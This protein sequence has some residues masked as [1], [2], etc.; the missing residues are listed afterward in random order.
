M[1]I[2]YE[3]KI[4]DNPP[5]MRKFLFHLL[6]IILLLILPFVV[7]IR[8]AVYL[9]EHYGAFAW[10]SILGGILMSALLILLY[11]IYLQGALTGRLGNLQM[12]KRQYW[13]ALAMVLVYCVPGLLFLSATNAKHPEVQEEFRSLHPVLRLGVSTLIWLDNDLV[14]TDGARRPED[15]GRMGLPTK[16][17]SLH[18]EQSDGYAHAVDI[19]TIR[20]GVLRNW[21]IERY[22]RLMG[23]NTL[24]HV[25]TADHLHVSIMSHDRPGGM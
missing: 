12:L 5:N 16:S 25:G 20:Q 4:S 17:H 10:L 6:K 11:M 9:H 24:R 21:L 13:L 22:F 8:G 3:R 7:L 1:K 18:Y 15:Y 23:F 2:R 14:V 19:R